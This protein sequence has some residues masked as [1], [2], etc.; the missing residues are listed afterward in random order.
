MRRRLDI[1]S[2]VTQLETVKKNQMSK[3]ETQKDA[4]DKFTKDHFYCRSKKCE[5]KDV[6]ILSSV[7]Q[8]AS[9][10]HDHVIIIGLGLSNIIDLI[11]PLRVK[12][13]GEM[14]YIVLLLPEDIPANL[15]QR[16]SLYDG[17]FIVRGSA[18]EE[19]NLRRAGI[20]RASQVVILADS[21]PDGL[22]QV[23]YYVLYTV[24]YMIMYAMF[25]AMC[26]VYRHLSSNRSL[27]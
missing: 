15:W 7:E 4:E 25:D 20:F 8:E 23:P 10:I 19:Q 6:T 12:L 3:Q 16:I 22:T 18:L 1:K 21:S 2:L 11:R 9:H 13:L 5:A 24:Y 27:G 26:N 14:K 17:I